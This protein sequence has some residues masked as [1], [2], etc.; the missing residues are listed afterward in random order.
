MTKQ[1]FYLYFCPKSTLA[2]A[3]NKSRKAVS[4]GRNISLYAL[5]KVE[6]AKPDLFTSCTAEDNTG[7][8]QLHC[9]NMK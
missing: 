4:S 9:I 7:F 5:K 8:V 6:V 3:K 1:L 2:L